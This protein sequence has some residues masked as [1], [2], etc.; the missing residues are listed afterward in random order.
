ML[1]KIGLSAIGPTKAGLFALLQKFGFVK[2][3][4]ALATAQS[5]AMG[6]SVVT[7][8]AI[9]GSSIILVGLLGAGIAR[10]RL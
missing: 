4:G 10:A 7:A 5:I 2:A 1:Q 9:T 8:T 3:G 6:G